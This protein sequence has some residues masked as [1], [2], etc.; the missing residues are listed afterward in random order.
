MFCVMH[1][2]MSSTTLGFYSSKS[3]CALLLIG[4]FIISLNW[5]ESSEDTSFVYNHLVVALTSRVKPV[6]PPKCSRS[7]AARSMPRI[8][9][10]FRCPQA[11]IECI[12][13]KIVIIKKRAIYRGPLFGASLFPPCLDTLLRLESPLSCG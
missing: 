2:I 10:T 8:R 1:S 7:H 4:T 3:G 13:N 9:I 12:K 5:D 11:W 6:K